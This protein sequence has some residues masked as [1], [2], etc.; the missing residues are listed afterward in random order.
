MTKEPI[1]RTF[2]RIAMA[3]AAM[4]TT[5][6]A[7]TVGPAHADFALKRFGVGVSSQGTFSRQAGA[8]ADLTTVIR[9]ASI[10]DQNGGETPD[11]QAR[12]IKIELPAG[13]AGN[14]TAAPTCTTAQLVGGFNGKTPVCPMGSQV[15]HALVFNDGS[16]DIANG[17]PVSVYNMVAP[18]DLPGLFA[19]NTDGAIVYIRPT[20]RSTDYGIDATVPAVS[21][22]IKFYGAR[23]DLWGVPGDPVH[24]AERVDNATGATNNP[25]PVSPVPFLTNP[26]SCIPTP[27]TFEASADSWLAPAD[28]KTASTDRDLDGTPFV[29]DGCDRLPFAPSVTVQPGS[30]LADA[31]TGLDVDLTVP[32][33]DDPDGL[34]TAHVR[35]V[36]V[37]LP[38][39]MSVSPSSAAGLGACAPEEIRLGSDV[40]PT[41]PESSRLGTVSID[42]PLLKAPLEGDVLLAKQ[43]DN[44]FHSLLALY[45]VAR[46]PGVLV[47]LAGRVDPDPVTGRLT[48]TFDNTPQLPFSELHVAFRGGPKAPLATPTA[49]GRYT[50]HAEITSWASDVPVGLDTPMVIDQGCDARAFAVSFSA[51]S[52][53]PGAGAD[54][55]FRLSLT[56]ADRTQYLSRID[57]Q[58]PPG[59][60]ARIASVARCPEEQ[61]AA[62]S[63]GAVSQIGGTSVLSG[64]GE[65][66]LGLTG[67]VYLTGPY[68]DAPFGLSIVVPTAGQAGPF[69]LGDVVVRAG[70]YVDRA[71][72]HVTVKSDPLPTIIRG[73]PLRLRQVVVDIDRAG[74][75][76]NPTNCAPAAITG[77]FGSV[78]GDSS[79]LLAAFRSIGCGELPVAPKLGLRFTGR[80]ATTDGKHPGVSA[81]LTT[82]P[83]SAN[84][85]TAT[86]KLP[87]SVA[88]D[89]D[90]AQALCK[91][92]QR[93]AL[94]CPA[95]SI[96]GRASA[97][98][99]LPDPLT[100]PVYFVQGTRVSKTGRVISTLP[101][102]W[103]PLSG[104][105]VTIDVNADSDVDSTERLVTTF[106]DVP[107]APISSFRLDL[108]GGRHGILVVSG[109]PGTCDRAKTLDSQFVGHNGVVAETVGQVAVDGCKPRLVRSTTTRRSVTLRVGNLG[110]GRLTVT[111]PLVG[112][113]SRTLKAATEAS[114]TVRLTANARA[115]LRR[116]ERIRVRLAVSFKPKTGASATTHPA[117]TVK[118]P[119]VA[120]ARRR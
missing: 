58:L 111:G 112:R 80:T 11:G 48:A 66:P 30:H 25:S 7:V 100:G 29:F 52:T 3:V 93:A 9:F 27:L 12:D 41:C 53:T 61:A 36:A 89:P 63:C 99:I 98:S 81:T 109:K 77:S 38:E 15:G 106:H 68:R 13:F 113:A 17:I 84:L 46:G 82:Q 43:D 74:F 114:I 96:V 31:P 86:V 37:T 70:I 23:V 28:V 59:L 103:I 64:P 51:G 14:P 117:V 50:T 119:S 115:A 118:A 120:H 105:G 54:S 104:D 57:A 20:V 44:P 116:H 39:G 22:A 32:Q 6:L 21:Q 62:G 102:L 45:L 60:L 97:R 88:L 2:A 67:R 71:D 85:R 56:R 107:D 33:S 19:F 42:T 55:A 24:D 65:T 40:A 10:K 73:F 91:P 69:D 1:M 79:V 108:T 26:T 34:A 110:A 16:D 76:F 78:E 72:A 47:K 95:A 92:Q 87:L 5:G 83:G 8:H 90:N 49:C 75:M 35:R 4:S 101:K 94:A 18:P